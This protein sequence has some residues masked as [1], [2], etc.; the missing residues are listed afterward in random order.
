[1]RIRA[2]VSD[3][4]N[5]IWRQRKHRGRWPHDFRQA[6]EPL[7]IARAYRKA[8][9]NVSGNTALLRTMAFLWKSIPYKPR[10]LVTFLFIKAVLFE[11]R[12]LKIDE[13]TAITPIK[14]L[15]SLAYWGI[16]E[17][18]LSSFILTIDGA[19][20]RPVSLSWPDLMALTSVERQVRMDCV[21]GFRNNSIMEGVSV[22]RLL[23]E[24]GVAPQARR[25]V[26]HCLDG[27]YVSLELQDLWE[28]E[29]FL[30]HTINGEKLPK[31]G[32]PLRLA[33]PGKYGY[34]WA[35]WVQRLEVVTDGRKGYWPEL[36]LP[37]RGDIGDVW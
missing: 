34:Q 21:G 28:K 8:L 27:Y 3:L 19:V 22:Q 12:L 14:D 37:D 25:V 16:P 11:K 1:M 20:D 6:K 18:D 24:A 10:R 7:L 4:G 9:I 13:Q 35:K 31:F 5:P 29:A 36:G 33:I 17:V 30:A 26:F 23:D 32:H 15:G 2:T